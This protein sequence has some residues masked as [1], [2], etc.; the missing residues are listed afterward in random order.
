MKKRFQREVKLVGEEKFSRLQRAGVILFGLG[1]VG[2]AAAEAL[3]RAGV[4]R[5]CLVD[6]DVLEETNVNRQIL[7]LT[8]TL[9][10]SKAEAAKRRVLEINPDCQVEARA[11]FYSAE[12]ADRFDLS[13]YTYA[14]DAIDTVTS[15]LLLA[16]RCQAAGVPLISCMGTGN[17]IDP[18]Q[19]RVS[20]LFKTESDPIARVMRRELRKHGGDRLNVVWSPEPPYRAPDEGKPG[21]L[22]FVPPAAG[23]VLAGKVIRDIMEMESL[24]G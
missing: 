24:D 2:G 19:F 12:T 3:A 21:T 13:A 4:G 11:E 15:K 6:P 1:G 14:A 20:D 10:M 9:G 7:A 23:L 16:R 17:K 8:S 5:L 22:S 18:T